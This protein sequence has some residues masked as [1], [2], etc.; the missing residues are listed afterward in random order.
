[1]TVSVAAT[2]T[3]FHGGKHVLRLRVLLSDTQLIRTLT[4]CAHMLGCVLRIPSHMR[5]HKAR[6][7]ARGI[8]INIMDGQM[9]AFRFHDLF[10][11]PGCM[12]NLLRNAHA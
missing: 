12:S 6:H 7:L 3:I 2:L 5:K 9:R 10:L 8:I 11:G 1:M 4:F